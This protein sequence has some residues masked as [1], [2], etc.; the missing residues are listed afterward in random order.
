MIGAFVV[1]PFFLLAF[2]NHPSFDDYQFALRDLKY[3]FW[4]TQ[5]AVYNN[6]SG[7]F[8]AT[9][10]SRINPL[11]YHSL[12]A[13]KALSAAL[14][15][16]MLAT[17]FF[18]VKTVYKDYCSK[19]ELGAMCL[20]FI[21]MYLVQM[22]DIAQGLYWFSSYAAYQFAN[23]LTLLLCICLY[24]LLHDNRKQLKLIYGALAAILGVA[25]IGLNE[26]SMVGTVMLLAFILYTTWRKGSPTRFYLLILLL[27]YVV[28]GLTVA[29]APGNYAR[30]HTQANPSNLVISLA[31]ALGFTLM[32]FYKWGSILAVASIVYTLMWGIPIAKDKGK[33]GVFDADYRA[34]LCCYIVSVAG[35]YF[36]FSW[37]TGARAGT[38]VENVIYF[39]FILGWF[40]VLQLILN[41]YFSDK[42]VKIDALGQFIMI[43][44]V[45][46]LVLSVIHI[47]SNVTTA[48][49]DL[50]A[51]NARTFDEELT[52]RYSYIS[53]SSSD[54]CVV[55]ALTVL[56]KSLY[57]WHMLPKS[58]VEEMG[59]NGS[60]ATYWGKE[61]I[62]I[63]GLLPAPKDNVELLK[64]IGK[65]VQIKIT[66]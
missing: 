28:A 10:V 39:Y 7:R 14:L 57:I 62:R 3:S 56:P 36:V 13:Y 31:G 4:E 43:P 18:T 41:K 58:E 25:V 24:Y 49:L 23:I 35:M 30:M 19:S 55:P 9:A 45:F 12:A 27:I 51:G 40:Y 52:K 16:I 2:Y 63:N 44:S 8:F 26:M 20:L 17:L 46:A 48:Y 22:P 1:L 29:L 11:I 6:W 65:R 61:N 64:E 32:A 59:V 66:K 53:G 37:A 5:V 42:S 38:R 47:N 33:N 54:T 60:F 50:I 21:S 15:A 34:A